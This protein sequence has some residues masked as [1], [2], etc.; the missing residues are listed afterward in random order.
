VFIGGHVQSVAD[1]DDLKQKG[2]AFGE[3]VLADP[4]AFDYWRSAEI[5]REPDHGFF[6]VAHGPKEGPPNELRNVYAH[7]VPLFTQT[8]EVAA[9][10]GW[11]LL[12]LHFYSDARFLK[13]EVLEAK[14]HALAQLTAYAQERGVTLCL[15]NLSER[16]EDFHRLAEHIPDLRITLDAGHA[17]LLAK[18]NTAFKIIQEL[19]DR[20]A[21]VHLH[22]NRG[23]VSYEDDLHLPLGR[24]IIDLNGIVNALVRIGYDQT[25]TLELEPHD[26]VDS[27]A[28]LEAWLRD[29][30]E[31]SQ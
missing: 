3:V 4:S 21:H 7:C 24:G 11:N 18:E 13:P 23:G 17:Q 16:A 8:I 14:A 19:P 6:L 22:D 28:T 5:L 29:A 1:I 2:F 15:E 25:M 31:S 30:T 20:I 27:K 12:T 9:D 10:L 26:L